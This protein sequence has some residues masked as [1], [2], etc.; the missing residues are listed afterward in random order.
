MRDVRSKTGTPEA[1]DFRDKDGT[2]IVVD[3]TAATG[4][5]YFVDD[6]AT[7]REIGDQLTTS[8]I[9]TLTVT[10]NIVASATSGEGVKVDPSAPTFPW[11][12]LL[13]SIS[14]R[15]IGAA[16]PTYAVYIGGIRGYRYTV[17]DE[18]FIEYHLPHDYL[19][20]SD[21]YL[22]FHWSH[23]ATNVTGG[24]VT[25]AAEVSYAKG[26]N[27]AAFSAPITS[28]VVGTASVTQYQHIITEVQLSAA[29]PSASQLDS[30]SIE[31][32]GLI[33]CRVYLSANNLTISGGLAPKPFLHFADVHYQ[34]TNIGT[35]NKAPPFW[36]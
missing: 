8:T 18:S 12:D 24:T 23:N 3:M 34:S 26:H 29:S 35:K 22:H 16:D 33:L 25:W 28:T 17:N 19:P 4:R 7:I 36:T 2:P 32:D 11:H 14:I 15:G 10:D 5:A 1:E 9:G 30:D 31:V 27:Q 6:A 20:G 13:G 21:L